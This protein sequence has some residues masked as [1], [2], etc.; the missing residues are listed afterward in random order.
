MN[1]LRLCTLAAALASTFAFTTPVLAQ[2]PQNERGPF[3]LVHHLPVDGVAEI[4]AA[5]PN[6]LTL[7]YTSADAGALGLVDITDPA[8][9]ASL[10][11]ID[12]RLG[13][14]GEPTSVAVSPDGR[15]AV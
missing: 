2:S 8:R 7:L 4:V 14:V 13:G 1:T 9:P 5:T 12:V 3:A 15:Y 6:G 11:R 10:P